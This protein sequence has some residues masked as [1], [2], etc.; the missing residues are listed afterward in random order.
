V[1]VSGPKN[2]SP[3]HLHLD[4]ELEYKNDDDIIGAYNVSDDLCNT[5]ISQLIGQLVEKGQM[6]D[7][8]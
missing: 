2:D 1:V 5:T 3:T 8:K 4:H 6:I 7:Q